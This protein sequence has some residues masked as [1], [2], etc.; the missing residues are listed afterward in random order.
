MSDN[1]AGQAIEFIR[2]MGFLQV[3]VPFV[4]I[5]AI[6]FG[7]LEKIQM[8]GKGK[9]EL[10]ALIAIG[11][12]LLITISFFNT[13][14]INMLPLIGVLFF[15]SFITLTLSKWAGLDPSFSKN[16]STNPAIL[17]PVA[18]LVVVV[19][20][21]IASGGADFIT[22]DFNMSRDLGTPSDNLTVSDMND[23]G[24]V[25]T[26]PQVAGTVILLILFA[27]VSFM[28]TKK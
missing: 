21:V 6:M 25:L 5:A 2:D 9:K 28:M 19:V 20:A 7:I 12:S 16:I 24:T 10:N 11:I 26:Q 27:V 4:V 1:V 15:F 13:L 17:I 3:I 8:F 22:G 18:I 23:I 14:V